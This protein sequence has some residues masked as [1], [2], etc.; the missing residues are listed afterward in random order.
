MSDPGPAPG[1]VRVRFAPSPT[2]NLHIGGAR[3]ALFNWLYARHLGGTYVLRIEDTDRERSRP[4]YL[5]EI[6]DSLAWLGLCHD[7]G[8]L[9]QSRRA[10]K[11]QAAAD[12]LLLSRHAYP[13]FCAPAEFEA[14]R[15]EAAE[16]GTAYR[17]DRRCAGLSPAE[18]EER[19]RRGMRPALRLRVPEGVST[20]DDLIRGTISVDHAQLDDF[21]IMKGDGSPTYHFAVVV[22][23]VDMEISHVIRGEDHISNTPKQL[24]LYEALGARPP[25]FAHIPLIHGADGGR[26]SKRHGATAVLE[27]RRRGFLPEALVNYLALLGW[28][29]GSDREIMNI[30]ELVERFDLGRVVKTP[31][32]F[33]VEKLT[34]MNGAYLAALSPSHLTQLCI[35][36]WQ[37]AGL[38]PPGDELRRIEWLVEIV[39]AVGDRLKLLPDILTYT[40]FF[41]TEIE[42]DE[43]AAAV[44]KK[45]AADRVSFAKIADRLQ[46][47]PEFSRSAVEEVIRGVMAEDSLSANRVIQPIRAAV[48][49]GLVSPGL[50]ESLE[51]LGREKSLERIRRRL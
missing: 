39:T 22:D 8:P 27:Y 12:G 46:A 11:Y 33:D 13:C 17:Y 31:A 4:E 37:E 48:S 36:L 1:R 21:I 42:P 38:L 29:P 30:A 15:V 44:L 7:E 23:D 3:T 47:L 6:L 35:P 2:G 34:W 32:V 26:L 50:F 25:R 9:L 28:S 14:R 43:K 16:R 20:W 10:D 41:F 19:C 18:V 40:R 49:G 45:A 51:L 24:V 5:R